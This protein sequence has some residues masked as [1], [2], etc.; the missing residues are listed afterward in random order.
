MDKN[1]TPSN[2]VPPSSL[3][4][5]NKQPSWREWRSFSFKALIFGFFLVFL[6]LHFADPIRLVTADLGRHLKNGE[7]ILAGEHKVFTSNF[8]SYTY[9]D[10]PF[11]NHH[12]ATGVLFYGIYR[13]AGFAGLSFFYIALL[14]CG[15]LVYF[16]LAKNFSSFS[17]AIF[18][19]VVALPLMSDRLEIR[20]EGITTLLIGL[21]LYL[22]FMYRN[23]K[24]SFKHLAWMIPLLQVFWVNTHILFFIGGFLVFVFW[25][26][27]WLG[28]RDKE[29]V[30]NFFILGLLVAAACFINPAGIKGALVPL[31]IFKEYGYRLA[32]NQTVFFMQKRFGHDPKYIYFEVLAVLSIVG[33]VFFCLRKKLRASI[34]EIF[35]LLFFIIFGLKTVRSMASF[36]FVFVPLMSLFC[37]EAVGSISK[38]VQ[39]KVG[40]GLLVIALMFI[41]HGVISAKSFFSPCGHLESFVRMNG[42]SPKDRNFM[43]LMRHPEIFSGLVPG[44]N[45]SAEFF[46]RLN[47]Q[48]PMFNNYDIGGYLIFNFSGQV[49]VFVDNRPEVYS[50]PFFKDVYVPMQENNDV[51]HKIDKQYGFNVIYFYRHDLTPWGQNFMVNRVEDPEWA[52]VYVDLFTIIFLKRNE[53]NKPIIDAFE[54]PRSMF[55]VSR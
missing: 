1:Q 12:W 30:R 22:M 25:L 47:I 18:F 53:Q 40:L 11:I 48:G 15:F 5:R 14:L 23:G 42:G 6:A 17:Y 41:G 50:V 7:L 24:I 51:W 2:V 20:P 26:D 31:T 21:Y 37:Y 19:S 10:Y 44:I 45:G 52:P 43:Y 38:E 16:K 8:Y 46:K 9:P 55:S 35:L 27:A 39:R 13:M 28:G 32:E 34:A 29:I 3:V 33:L 49:K 36:A 4:L 54:L